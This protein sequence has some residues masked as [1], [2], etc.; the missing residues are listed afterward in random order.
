MAD[1]LHA[2]QSDAEAFRTAHKSEQAA[3]NALDITRKQYEV[4]QVSYQILLA[5]DQVYQQSTITLTQ[6]QTNR[7]GDTAALYQALGG[8]WWHRTDEAMLGTQKG[9]QSQ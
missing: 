5:A 3:K 4:G 6:I 1:T 8:G 2:I 9:E 7:F